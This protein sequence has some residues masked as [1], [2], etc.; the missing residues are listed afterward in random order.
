[1]QDLN[2]D[3]DLGLDGLI[4]VLLDQEFRFRKDEVEEIFSIIQQNHVFRYREFLI[5]YN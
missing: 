4:V 2:R 3:G 5:Q 1:M